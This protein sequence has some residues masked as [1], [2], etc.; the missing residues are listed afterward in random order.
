MPEL[1][2]VQTVVADLNEKIKGDTIVDFWSGWPKAIKGKSLALFTKEIA[3]R[4]IL[5]ARRIGKNIFIDLSGGKTLYLH[6]KMTGHLLV[7]VQNP[8]D[9]FQS[10]SK[11]QNPKSK[12]EDYF[13]DRVNQYIRHKFYLKTDAKLRNIDEST[14]KKKMVAKNFVDSDSSVCSHQN[15]KVMEFSDMRKFAKIMLVNTED[16]REIPEIKALGTDAMSGELTLQKFNG[17]LDRKKNTPIGILLM[18]Q[19]L[20]AGI[21]NIYRSEILFEA[22]ILPTRKAAD[23]AREERKKLFRS[24]GKILRKA[25]KLRGTSDS[26]YRDTSGAPGGYQKVL[27]VYRKAGEKCQRCDTIIKR[28]VLGQ[29]SVFYCPDCQK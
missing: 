21:G 1:P 23:I 27:Q 14:N 15:D 16:I 10:K 28:A 9:K 5:G 7:K 29:R 26:D 3:G 4:K 8:N 2:E 11:I 13:E 17:I 20:I 18:D 6:L 25:V 22:G 12:T 19:S 24:I